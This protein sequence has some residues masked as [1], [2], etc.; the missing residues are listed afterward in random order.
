[1]TNYIPII[2]RGYSRKISLDEIMYLEQRQRRLAIV[3]E[4]ETFLFY[5]RLENLEKLLDERFYRSLKKLRVNI[6]NILVAED[7]KITFVNGTT[8][9]LG[10]ES[11]IRTKQIYSAYLKKLI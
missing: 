10:R 9:H 1:M 2:T 6:E 7:Q 11:Y 8:L 4:K 3:T 5:E